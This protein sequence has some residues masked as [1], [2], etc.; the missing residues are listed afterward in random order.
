MTSSASL[1]LR[2]RH[3]A[4]G[5]IELVHDGSTVTVGHSTLGADQCTYAGQGTSP[6][7]GTAG[8]LLRERSVGPNGELR[9][10]QWTYKVAI[11][12]A[13]DPAWTETCSSVNG[14]YTHS[15]GGNASGSWLAYLGESIDPAAPRF[16]DGGRMYGSY[17]V[18]PGSSWENSVSWSICRQ[19]VTCPAPPADEKPCPEPPEK[20]LLQTALA[21][22]KMLMDQF[23]AKFDEYAKLANEA[24]QYASDFELAINTC[25]RIRDLKVLLQ[26]LVGQGPQNIKDFN[27][28]FG[29]VKNILQGNATFVADDFIGK[30]NVLMN[31]WGKIMFI[32]EKIAPAAASSLRSQ[33]MPCAGSNLDVVFEGAMNFVQL[34]EQIEPVMRQANKLLNDQ[35]SKDQEIFDLW[36]KYRPACLEHAKCMKLPASYCEKLPSI[37][38]WHSGGPQSSAPGGGPAAGRSATSSHQ[39]PS[40]SPSSRPRPATAARLAKGFISVAVDARHSGVRIAFRMKAGEPVP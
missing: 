1:R 13:V 39:R 35:R 30:R 6:A 29:V 14:P 33:L 5:T 36:S 15:Y 40:G 7:V 26:L 4:D 34:M 16:L 28:Y 12:P 25:N 24:Q 10:G 17:T 2:E 8:W 9:L 22:Q 27:K 31:Q 19:G 11:T 20:A 37:E 18:A 32:V 21:Q 38:G 3:V 23:N